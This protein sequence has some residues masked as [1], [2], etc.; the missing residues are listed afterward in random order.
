MREDRTCPACGRPIP[1]ATHDQR[2]RKYCDHRCY[3]VARWGPVPATAQGGRRQAQRTFPIDGVACPCGRPAQVR[4]HIDG[5]PTNNAP[6][7]VTLLCLGCHGRLHLT[8]TRCLR[9]HPLEG[10]NVYV[11]PRGHRSCR[12]CRALR[13]GPR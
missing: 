12:A 2:R 13:E 5:N 10:D 3:V 11:S 6:E 7:N 9:G 1:Q 8:K 4:H